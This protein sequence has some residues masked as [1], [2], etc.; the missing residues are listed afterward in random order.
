MAVFPALDPIYAAP[1]QTRNEAQRTMLGDGYEKS[2]IFGLN[3][4]RP[5]W[6]LTWLLS[7]EDATTI[8]GF[9]QARSDAAEWFEW[10]PPDATVTQRWRCDEWTV[11]Q[12]NPVVFRISATFRRVFELII[13]SLQSALAICPADILCESDYGDIGTDFWVSVMTAPYANV[14]FAYAANF[15]GAVAAATIVTDTMG[16][17]YCPMV[18]TDRTFAITKRKLNGEVIWTKE[19]SFADPYG[20]WL[21]DSLSRTVIGDLGNGKESIACFLPS[22]FG[23]QHDNMAVYNTNGEFIHGWSVPGD[24]QPQNHTIGMEYVRVQKCVMMI[25]HELGYLT[26]DVV[27]ALEGTRVAGY[28]FSYGR[29]TLY[30]T[31]TPEAAAY[32]QFDNGRSILFDKRAGYLVVIPLDENFAPLSNNFNQY[33]NVGTGVKAVE[34]GIGCLVATSETLLYF[35]KSGNFISR[36]PISCGVPDELNADS[37]GVYLLTGS[38]MSSTKFNLDLSVLEIQNWCA[39]DNSGFTANDSFNA[40]N[41]GLAWHADYGYHL[42]TNRVVSTKNRFSNTAYINPG[43]Y[44][45]F[46]VFGG[47]AHTIGGYTTLPTNIYTASAQ[48]FSLQTPLTSYNTPISIGVINGSSSLR[49]GTPWAFSRTSVDASSKY[50]Y[51]LYSTN[52]A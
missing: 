38:R 39:G 44:P 25:R 14:T 20:G 42:P 2:L 10:Q 24:T 16:N 21:D 27:N 13:P 34:Y 35:D 17:T 12:D 1:K 23:Y 5:E 4:I 8:E 31:D 52:L 26:F 22:Y 46:Q 28:E 7:S 40:E 33:G 3:T 6:Q 43:T 19:H 15:I 9:L 50:Q 32:V 29:L 49:T 36:T 41:L 18:T 47:R 30:S 37:D 45:V 51:T 11:E 48:G